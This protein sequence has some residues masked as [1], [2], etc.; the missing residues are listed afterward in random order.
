[1]DGL[2]FENSQ[3]PGHLVIPGTRY[4]VWQDP[5]TDQ[6]QIQHTDYLPEQS[7]YLPENHES[8]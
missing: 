7:D 6:Q 5:G 8:A 3:Y 1:M 2:G 4:P